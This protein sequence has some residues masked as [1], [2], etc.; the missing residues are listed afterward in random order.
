MTPGNRAIVGPDILRRQHTSRRVQGLGKLRLYWITTLQKNRGFYA[1]ALA[2]SLRNYICT[3]QEGALPEIFTEAIVIC[4]TALTLNPMLH[5]QEPSD[6][7]KPK[8]LHQR[9]VW[10]CHWVFIEAFEIVA[11]SEIP[12]AVSSPWKNPVRCRWGIVNRAK[13][14]HNTACHWHYN[15]SCLTGERGWSCSLSLSFTAC[16]PLW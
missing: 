8:P 16:Q 15:Y 2:M 9:H 11:L 1:S 6:F 10:C 3:W 5:T 14:L 7:Q 4:L 12:L 13:M